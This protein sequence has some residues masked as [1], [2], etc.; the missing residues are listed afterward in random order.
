MASIRIRHL[1]TQ[2]SWQG[3]TNRAPN[4]TV[5]VANIL[6]HA[7]R[8]QTNIGSSGLRNNRVTRANELAHLWPQACL[9]QLGTGADLKR[10]RQYCLRV[11]AVGLLGCTVPRAVSGGVSARASP[12]GSRQPLHQASQ[13]LCGVQAHDVL[14]VNIDVLVTEIHDVFFVQLMREA[15]RVHLNESR[16]AGEQEIRA[17]HAL[18][19]ARPRGLTV[20][21]AQ[22]QWVLL[23]Q[24]R[25]AGSHLCI[26]QLDLVDELGKQIQEPVALRVLVDEQH[27]VFRRRKFLH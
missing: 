15:T 26:R 24:Q 8:A 5:D 17:F 21:G 13:H 11:H 4:S 10:L 23:A 20:I 12:V 2:Q 9:R 6:R 1:A 7:L 19:H 18:A 16:G 22:K 27:R 25:L 3:I 14:A